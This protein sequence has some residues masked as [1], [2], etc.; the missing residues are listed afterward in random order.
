MGGVQT[1]LTFVRHQ[2][3][4]DVSINSVADCQGAP[5]VDN[6]GPS[7]NPCLDMSYNPTVCPRFTYLTHR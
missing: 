7:V 3:R 1:H 6:P 5:L 4:D 2:R